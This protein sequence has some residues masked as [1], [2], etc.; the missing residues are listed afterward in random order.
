VRV[1]STNTHYELLVSPSGR[2]AGAASSRRE[3]AARVFDRVLRGER[4]KVAAMSLGISPPT[5]AQ[6]V[7]EVATDMN[8]EGRFS[9]L[10]AALAIL[11]HA[12]QHP[13]WVTLEVEGELS[14][15]QQPQRLV[16]VS[17]CENLVGDALTNSQ[18]DVA[19]QLLEGST[20][21]Q[22]AERRRTSVRTVANQVCRVF[23]AF[24][25]T[26]RF[27]L[28]RALSERS[29]GTP[30]ASSI[31]IQVARLSVFTGTPDGKERE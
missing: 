22:I 3:L 1:A 2:G 21:A 16:R 12:A 26:G 13:D 18:R 11:A 23:R 5:V 28:L 7:G 8:L 9:R 20:Y 24:R 25:V 14:W 6:M 19:T 29:A 10:P 31:A 27:E 30:A 15:Q 17:L 4:Q